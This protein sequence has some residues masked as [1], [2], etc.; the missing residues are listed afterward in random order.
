LL[1]D[2]PSSLLTDA[3]E[4]VMEARA[5]RLK[6]HRPQLHLLPR[7]AVEEHPIALLGTFC[8]LAG[9][10]V[11]ALPLVIYDWAKASHAALELPMAVSAWLFGLNHFDQNG[12]VVWA[13]IVGAVIARLLGAQRLAFAALA[14]RVYGVRSRSGSLALGTVWSFVSF[15][16]FWYMLLPI[17]REG[18]PFRLGSGSA[19]FVAL[20]SRLYRLRA[21]DGRVLSVAAARVLR[22]ELTKPADTAKRR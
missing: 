6:R 15:M 14:D 18:A 11:R 7:E 20:D 17:A 22:P 16:F 21:G 9:G 5:E 1:K 4:V 8:G 2:D 19:G 13:I 3:M 12:Y 10:L